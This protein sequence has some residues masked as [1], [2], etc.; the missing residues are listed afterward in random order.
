MLMAKYS[1]ILLKSR[2]TRVILERMLESNVRQALSGCTFKLRR[3]GGVF[4]IESNN[5]KECAERLKKVF[6]IVRI[7]LC[8]VVPAELYAIVEKCFEIGMKFKRNSSFAIR[9]RRVGEHSFSSRQICVEAGSR[10]LEGL[11]KK[12][13]KVNLEE[14]DEEIFVDVRWDRAFISRKNIKTCGG[15]PLGS[16]GKAVAVITD[17]DSYNAAWMMMRRGCEIIAVCGSNK[18]CKLA[19][20][21][22]E[23]HIGKEMKLHNLSLKQSRIS[24]KELFREAG[25]L[26]G[27]TGALAI[28]SGESFC[29]KQ[30]I[31]K[32]EELD[33]LAGVSV[34]RPLIFLED[35]KGVV[36]A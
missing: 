35:M 27:K 11:K 34:Y 14:P 30:K 36:V 20:E 13:L 32:L 15:M 29:K 28:V 17:K 8:N 21:L 31:D 7:S 4:L 25:R 22:K 23:W 12:K 6:G 26:A 5:E 10:I 33:E 24:R 18:G 19:K 16:Q 1:E 2:M 3:G 9:A